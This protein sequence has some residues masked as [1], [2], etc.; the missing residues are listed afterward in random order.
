MTE[1]F[2]DR[3]AY[4]ND[5]TI[6]SKVVHLPKISIVAFLGRPTLAQRVEALVH[7][8]QLRGLVRMLIKRIPPAALD[9]VAE[10]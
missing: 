4:E 2:L 1:T 3:G 5:G 8:G 7:S 6:E 9:E 10:T